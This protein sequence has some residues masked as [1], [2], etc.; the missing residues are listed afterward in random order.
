MSVESKQLPVS[1]LMWLKVLILMSFVFGM[2]VKTGVWRGRLKTTEE[3]EGEFFFPNLQRLEHYFALF[4]FNSYDF[5]FRLIES[6]RLEENST[7][8]R[9]KNAGRR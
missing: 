5:R 6:N 2:V 3:W 1:A 8:G 4:S 9:P 7:N